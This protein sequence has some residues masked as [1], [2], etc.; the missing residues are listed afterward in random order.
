MI[1][2]AERVTIFGGDGCRDAHDEVVAL[3]RKLKAPVGYAFRGKQYLEYEN[4]NAVGMTGLIGY[5]GAYRAMHEADC[6]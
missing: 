3:A 5:G 4:P 6:C 1:N 2:A